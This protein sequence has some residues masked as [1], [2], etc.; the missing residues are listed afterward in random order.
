M[1]PI[2]RIAQ[3]DRY[4]PQ[5]PA[6]IAMDGCVRVDSPF[7]EPP[8]RRLYTTTSGAL[9]HFDSTT[10][11]FNEENQKE[12]TQ[13]HRRVSAWEWQCRCKSRQFDDSIPRSSLIFPCPGC[14]WPFAL[15]FFF[16]DLLEPRSSCHRFTFR[17]R[18][19]ERFSPW[20]P[21]F[22]SIGSIDCS[23]LASPP[24]GGNPRS[25]RSDL[26]ESAER[27]VEILQIGKQLRHGRPIP[28]RSE[29]ASFHTSEQLV[30]TRPRL[31]ESISVSEARHHLE[32]VHLY[33]RLLAQCRQFP[34]ENSKGPLER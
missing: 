4:T 2:S 5:T 33:V 17:R 15:G 3:E 21:S 14:I 9:Q 32:R 11:R 30:G 24:N 12:K 29:P 20:S 18:F 23:Q 26:D 8:S 6:L 22:G 27:V 13:R 10:T 16:F 19:L 25:R 7:P 28:R 31:S 34:Q 1:R